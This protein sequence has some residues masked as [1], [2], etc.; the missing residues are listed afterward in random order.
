M[1]EPIIIGSVAATGKDSQSMVAL[2][3]EGTQ[4][5]QKVRVANRMPRPFVAR[6]WGVTL[7]MP[8]AEGSSV[9]IDVPSYGALQKVVGNL[10]Q[11]AEL[12]GWR[13][14][15]IIERMAPMSPDRDPSDPDLS[16]SA[17]GPVEGVPPQR[18]PRKESR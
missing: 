1:Q 14:A 7:A 18:K 13:E 15:A 11:I 8:P 6:E 10:A 16:G 2:A 17:D 9:E 12:N 5:P 3:F 4:F